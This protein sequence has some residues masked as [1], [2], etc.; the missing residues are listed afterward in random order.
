MYRTIE[1]ET[2]DGIVVIEVFYDG[3]NAAPVIRINDERDVPSPSDP[4]VTGDEPKAVQIF[5]NGVD[6]SPDSF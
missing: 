1:I 2:N 6:Y 5:I 4:E 3:G